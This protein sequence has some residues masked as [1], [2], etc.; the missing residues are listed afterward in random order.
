M[1]RLELL[2]ALEKAYRLAGGVA[3]SGQ[4]QCAQRT[5]LDGGL[6]AFQLHRARQVVV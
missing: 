5:A 4:R 6:D 1:P 2:A 3:G